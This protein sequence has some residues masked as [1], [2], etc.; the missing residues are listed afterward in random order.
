MS[1]AE[2]PGPGRAAVRRRSR[3]HPAGE[4]GLEQSG[5]KAQRETAEAPSH[6]D[7]SVRHGA[8][9]QGED[10]PDDRGDVGQAEAQDLQT[11]LSVGDSLSVW[12]DT[13]VQVE[14]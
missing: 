10:R 14:D 13:S 9:E 4:N 8:S 12:D 1:A 2:A 11:T 6:A 7:S 5:E 3:D